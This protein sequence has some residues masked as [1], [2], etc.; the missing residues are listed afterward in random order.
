MPNSLGD[1]FQA[2]KPTVSVA[3]PDNEQWQSTNFPQGHR[4]GP[5]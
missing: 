3:F 4:H 5:L 1:A 2:K